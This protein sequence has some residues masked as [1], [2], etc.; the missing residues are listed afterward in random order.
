MVSAYGA[1]RQIVAV[2]QPEIH[3]HP[4]LQADLGDVFLQS[5]LG[6]QQNHFVIETHSEHLL[7]RIMRRMRETAAKKGARDAVGD[8]P[9]VTPSDIMVLFVEPVGSKS[10]VREM[11][12]NENG[13]LVKA[14]PGGFFEE[15]L[16]EVF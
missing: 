13:E 4:A 5:A 11:P 10:I 1:E 15:G 2:E 12:L 7:L 3:L 8:V 16:R 14:C 6:P 9:S